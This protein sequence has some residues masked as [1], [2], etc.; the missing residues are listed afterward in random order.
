MLVL[1]T[2]WKKVQSKQPNLSFSKVEK[3]RCNEILHR[4]AKMHFFSILN[5]GHVAAVDGK[6]HILEWSDIDQ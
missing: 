5:A 4:V 1:V 3:Y 2:V 6:K